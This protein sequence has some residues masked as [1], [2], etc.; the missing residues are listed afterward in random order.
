[1]LFSAEKN[2]NIILLFRI[3]RLKRCSHENAIG[4]SEGQKQH[5]NGK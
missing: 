5:I 4:Q 3:D 2:I 1:M